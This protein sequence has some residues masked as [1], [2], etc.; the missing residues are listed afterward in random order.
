MTYPEICE[1][2][3]HLY[4]QL[5]Q[6]SWEISY[7]LVKGLADDLEILKNQKDGIREL[8]N[9]NL[10]KLE[11]YWASVD[12]Q[13]ETIRKHDSYFLL[14]RKELKIIEIYNENPDYSMK[15]I[16][17]MVC[18]SKETA[19]RA[20]TKYLANKYGKEEMEAKF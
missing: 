3:K 10:E 19:S 17:S 1:S 4:A 7:C 13:I 14:T 9:I 15:T 20:I 6:Y 11:E 16:G 18:V 2:N 12:F 8:I 5:E